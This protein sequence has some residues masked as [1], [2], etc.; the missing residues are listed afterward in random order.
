[1]DSSALA[2]WDLFPEF[3]REV[4]QDDLHGAVFELS[5]IGIHSV[6]LSPVSDQ[7]KWRPVVGV[8]EEWFR[9]VA[10]KLFLSQPEGTPFFHWADRVR[11]V[12]V[13]AGEK[14][15]G[16]FLVDVPEADQR[17]SIAGLKEGSAEAVELVPG[18]AFRLQTGGAGTESDEFRI[19]GSAQEISGGKNEG[20]ALE[21]RN[22][23]CVPWG[24][25]AAIRKE[26]AGIQR[27]GLVE[28]AVAGE[29]NNS[30]AAEDSKDGIACGGE[31]G[32]D[33][34]V[35][36]SASCKDCMIVFQQ[37][38]TRI[39]PRGHPGAIHRAA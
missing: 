3:L 20:T 7:N 29:V 19:H 34:D 5:W 24:P 6:M 4:G 22:L 39:F 1:M 35:R 9:S 26:K 28:K 33:D 11:P 15:M 30:G 27:I 37:V 10:Q 23:P 13:K 12:L 8:P 25:F 18:I 16:A 14:A 2:C 21:E 32:L 38:R 31:A 17:G 36:E